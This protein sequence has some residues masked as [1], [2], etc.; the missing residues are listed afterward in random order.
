MEMRLKRLR[1]AFRKNEC[2][3]AVD[4]G[5]SEETFWRILLPKMERGKDK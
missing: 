3:A 2:I 1:K 4:K 5:P